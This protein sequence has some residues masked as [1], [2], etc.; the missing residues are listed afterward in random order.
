MKKVEPLVR[1]LAKQIAQEGSMDRGI[2]FAMLANYLWKNPSI[3]GAAFAFAPNMKD[4]KE[5]KSCP[6]VHRRGD[7]LIEK[8]LTNSFDY[9]AP[10]QKWY[11]TPVR[12]GK[13][14]WSE[15]YYDK[16]G[17]EA[18][19]WTFSVPIYSGAQDRKLVGVVTSDILVPEQ[20]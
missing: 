19:M 6:Y 16:G 14:V 13:P 8:D 3:Y 7:H 11:A 20:Q 5:I 10:D 17:G 12:L 15:P 1:A 9:T 4:G 2:V 18:W